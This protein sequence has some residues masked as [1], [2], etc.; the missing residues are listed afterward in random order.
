MKYLTATALVICLF[1]TNATA[2][3]AKRRQL[4]KEYDQRTK[5]L[6]PCI[7]ATARA[8]RNGGVWQEEN[9]SLSECKARAAEYVG[10]GLKMMGA[11]ADDD[12][13]E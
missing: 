1:T 2:D 6:Q 9:L 10:L 13:E 8:Q 7:A 3:D 4:M 12:D 11:S 5:E